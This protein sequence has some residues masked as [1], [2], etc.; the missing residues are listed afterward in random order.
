M[1]I[2]IPALAAVG[3]LA[4]L[5]LFLRSEPGRDRKRRR[6]MIITVIV[7]AVLAIGGMGLLGIPG[8]LIYGVSLPFVQLLMGA[9]YT[10]LGDGMWPAAI[11]ITLVW[12]ASLVIAYAVANGPLRGR[13]R[14]ARWL[15]LLL[16]PWAFGVL[17]ALGAHLS[18]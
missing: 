12:P 3:A 6:G 18:V 11:L 14:G 10:E 4:A 5:V 7:A 16:I 8:A 9:R 13:G 1:W 2:L 15:A 17:L